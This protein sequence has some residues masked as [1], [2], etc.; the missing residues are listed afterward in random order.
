MPGL[1]RPREFGSAAM[2]VLGRFRMNGRNP[3]PLRHK[4]ANKSVYW[5]DHQVGV[6]RAVETGF[7]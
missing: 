5:F 4:V 7:A 1:R 6:Y 2:H 3:L